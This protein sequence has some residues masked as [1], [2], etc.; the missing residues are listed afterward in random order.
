MSFDG[1]SSS[2][3]VYSRG[4]LQVILVCIAIIAIIAALSFGKSRMLLSLLSIYPALLIESALEKTGLLSNLSNLSNL[5]VF[6]IHVISFLV[7]YCLIFFVLYRSFF[8]SSTTLKEWSLPVVL[9]ITVLKTGLMISVFIMYA[10][11]SGM[12]FGNSTLY[13]IWGSPIA[14]TLWLI[15]PILATSI[16]RGSVRRATSKEE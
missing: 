15:S 9:L 13:I 16:L 11:S 10:E 5:S 7:L 1:L 4:N 12:S 2:L 8:S 6:F 14:R 3:I